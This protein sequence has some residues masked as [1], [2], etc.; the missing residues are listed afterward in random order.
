MGCEGGA[1]AEAVV[2]LLC[3]PAQHVA[4]CLPVTDT[5]AVGP[6]PHLCLLL[7]KDRQSVLLSVP[8]I[9]C[10]CVLTHSCFCLSVYLGSGDSLSPVYSSW[11]FRAPAWRV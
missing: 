5:A 6:P 4:Q 3:R 7:T 1:A 9:I 8:Y 10:L 11:S 2:E